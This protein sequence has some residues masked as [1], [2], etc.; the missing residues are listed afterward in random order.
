MEQVIKIVI[1]RRAKIAL[2]SLQ[3]S[4]KKQITNALA[5]IEIIQPKNLFKMTKLNKINSFGKDLYIYRGNQRLRLVLSIQ[6][7]VC[8]V[9]DILDHDKLNRLV[10][11][12]R[13]Q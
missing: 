5:Q 4:E 8:I 1:Q 6:D 3:Q 10:A 7:D 2:R 9:E 13:Q 11:N 12:S